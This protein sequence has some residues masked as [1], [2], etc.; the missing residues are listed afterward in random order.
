[1]AR[2]DQEALFTHCVRVSMQCLAVAVPLLLMVHGPVQAATT[3]VSACEP[4]S[5]STPDRRLVA[6]ADEGAGSLRRYV[7]RTQ[8]IFQLDLATAVQRV[9]RQ[10]GADA[11]CSAAVASR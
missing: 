3:R 8:P 4:T 7:E 2:L 9:E 10:R 11:A 6:K 5:V 1:M